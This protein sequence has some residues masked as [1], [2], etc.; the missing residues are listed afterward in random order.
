MNNP[1]IS[2]IV[3]CYNQAQ[4]L[5]ECLQSV[6]D[7]TYTKWECII[8]NDGSPDNTEEIAKI[9]TL[10]DPRFKYFYKEN[11]GLSS[12]RNFGLNLANGAFVQLLDCDDYIAKN[13]LELQILDLESGD[14]SI[15]DYE[16]VNDNHEKLSL[17]YCAPFTDTGFS[18]ED[19]ILKWET[20]LSIP[21]HCVLFKRTTHRFNE[22]LK[23]HED[24]VFWVQLFYCSQ[25]II[26][27]RNVLAYYR[28]SANSMSRNI[29]EMNKGF[30]KACNFLFSYFREKKERNALLL[31]T[32]KK[33]RIRNTTKMTL[34]EIFAK[35]FPS[36]YN[37]Y[38]N[39]VKQ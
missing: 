14:I 24:W 12:A 37:S 35:K 11:G 1:L 29:N 30:L 7:Q 6:L 38:L 16:K 28:I 9:W 34:K 20:E 32:S 23:N 15:S 8:V 22:K 17:Q 27:N 10:K 25:K 33:R 4:Y 39:Y 26:Y 5:D 31:L 36:I 13:K 18:F 21:C 3:P 19:L 2:I